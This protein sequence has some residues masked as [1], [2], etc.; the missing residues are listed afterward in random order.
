MLSRYRQWTFWWKLLSQ[1][2]EE[3][4]P[5]SLRRTPAAIQAKREAK[6]KES[7]SSERATGRRDTGTSKP[8]PITGEEGRKA[9]E[10]FLQWCDAGMEEA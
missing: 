2:C 4:I 9:W 1:V 3:P 5:M 8:F 6:R 7:A 10:D